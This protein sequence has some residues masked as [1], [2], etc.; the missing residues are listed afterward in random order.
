MKHVN[1]KNAAIEMRG[2]GIHKVFTRREKELK[3]A[4]ILK[5]LTEEQL[6]IINDPNSDKE[7]RNKI[8]SGSW[9]KFKILKEY[10]FQVVRNH[11]RHDYSCLNTCI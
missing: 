8:K 2:K 9:K 3:E 11:I 7:E 4:F 6:L 5:T 10:L 1:Y